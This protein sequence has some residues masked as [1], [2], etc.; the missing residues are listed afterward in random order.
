MK[1]RQPTGSVPMPETMSSAVGGDPLAALSERVRRIGT[2]LQP[3]DKHH[4]TTPGFPVAIYSGLPEDARVEIA[5]RGVD[6][7][8]VTVCSKGDP[9]VR[10]YGRSQH[11]R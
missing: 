9:W 2:T 8:S 1:P 6:P 11:V 4:Q 3:Y 7:T 10:I 5:R